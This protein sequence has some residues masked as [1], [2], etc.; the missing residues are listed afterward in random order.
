MTSQINPRN[1]TRK[2]AETR[3]CRPPENA[4]ADYCRKL[5]NGIARLQDAIQ[6]YYEEAFPAE[7]ET[8]ASFDFLTRAPSNLT[9]ADPPPF[10]ILR[11]REAA[12]LPIAP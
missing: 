10:H 6:A 3:D 2:I 8:I 11:D 5:K 7:R 1:S 12:L 4:P 9:H